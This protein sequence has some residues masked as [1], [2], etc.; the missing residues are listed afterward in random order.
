MTKAI[1]AWAMRRAGLGDFGV[2]QA[3]HSQDV[4]QIQWPDR[5]TLR[6]WAKEQGWPIPRF[7][8]EKAFL[9]KMLE[10]EASFDLAIIQSGLQISIPKQEHTLSA[11]EVVELD[12]LYVERSADGR[13]TGWGSLV[14][15]LRE[16][17]RAVE[18]GVVVKI[19]ET[20]PLR[21]WQA[22]YSWAHGRYPMLEDGYDHW[23]GDDVS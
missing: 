1:P 6:G 15:G 3:P 14:A 16:I 2:V 8:F 11:A 19:D 5:E 18:A 12:D 20:R 9:A 21:S 22:F 13:P 4:L 7:R 17:R 23:I 10:N